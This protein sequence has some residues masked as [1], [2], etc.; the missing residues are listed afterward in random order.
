[1]ELVRGLSHLCERHKG[2]VA[3]VGT[4]DGLHLGHRALIRDALECAQRRSSR[5]L[6]LSFEPMPREFLQPAD[7][8]VRLTSLRERWR[9]LEPM[10]LDALL[11]LRFNAA[12][13]QLSGEQFIQV[14]HQQLR[15]A[16]VVVG[17]D[18]RFGRDGAAGAPQ[19]EAAGRR[20]GFEVRVMAPVL[21][22][23]E[24]VSSSAVREALAAGEFSAAHA[25]LGRPYTMRGRVV[26]GERLGR[27][28][29]Y[30]TA[31]LRLLRRRA[32]LAGVFA[33]RVHGIAAVPLAGVASLGTRPTVG[34]TVPL[35]EAHV[36]D[37]SADLYGREL[38]IEFVARIRD[39]E[40][41]DTLDALV[42]Q[43]HRDAHRAR[44]ILAA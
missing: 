34:G 2:C 21:L 26:G 17:H 13:R 42:E 36:F 23:M 8:P 31:N 14:L 39:E 15:V 5:A 4:F 18:F 20:L 43:M 7:P 16:A 25:L 24:R 38:A 9:L 37:F 22:N 12:L 41:F 32:P 40:R 29:G 28:L 33:V 6:M 35:L 30:P 11:L 19:L 1:M 27:Q 44:E 3:T 10:G